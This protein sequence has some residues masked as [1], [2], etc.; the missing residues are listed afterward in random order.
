MEDKEAARLEGLWGEG[1]IRAFISHKAEDKILA[2]NL[3][4]SLRRHG[5]ASFVAHMDIEPLEEWQDEIES[6]LFSMDI[7]VALMT[8][9]FS[10]SNWT[11]QEI[12]VAIGR[13]APIFS[14]RLGRDP[15]GFIGKYQAMQ[16]SGKN[17]E[18]ISKEIFSFLLSG[19]K[20]SD[21]LKDS[22]KGAY[23][24]AVREAGSF[25]DAKHLSDFLEMIDRLSP[26]QEE[27]LVE[28]FNQN[29]QVYK[30]FSFRREIEHQLERMTGKIY[31]RDGEKLYQVK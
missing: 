6:A 9:K 29:D 26:C 11:D 8:E 14:I 4:K 22:A 27:A 1:R 21:D 20:V 15:Y 7:L 28:A 18:E 23:I 16:G 17:A 25:D 30:S 12:G 10:E 5:I 13:Q 31:R 24:L 2:T 19:S 3:Q